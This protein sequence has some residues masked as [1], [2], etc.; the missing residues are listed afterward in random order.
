VLKA[1][2]TNLFHDPLR[3]AGYGFGQINHIPHPPL[4][5][6]SAIFSRQRSPT[7]T[8]N[9]AVASVEW[10]VCRRIN[11]ERLKKYGCEAALLNAQPRTPLQQPEEDD[12]PM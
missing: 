11:L 8:F 7:G 6:A 1:E 4:A 12:V 5:H 3:I 10:E 2:K 9:G